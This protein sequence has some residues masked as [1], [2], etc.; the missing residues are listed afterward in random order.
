MQRFR[1]ALPTGNYPGNPE[2][3]IRDKNGAFVLYEDVKSLVVDEQKK[4]WAQNICANFIRFNEYKEI[5]CCFC[6]A[7][8]VPMLSKFNHYETCIVTEA[9]KYLESMEDK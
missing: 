7:D 5:D 8:P 9:K 1:A 4:R 2:D 6:L 3:L